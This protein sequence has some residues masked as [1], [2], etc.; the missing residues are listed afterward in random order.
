M[1]EQDFHA[2]ATAYIEAQ[3]QADHIN[4]KHPMWWP[5]GKFFDLQR[6]HPEDCWRAILAVLDLQPSEKVLGMLAAGPLEDLIE[7]HG[8]QFIERIE[9]EA[10]RRSDFRSLLR[11]VWKSSTLEIWARVERACEAAT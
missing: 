11:G 5:I 8:E 6:E 7:D 3:S 9:I 4:E 2:W 10:R 1:T